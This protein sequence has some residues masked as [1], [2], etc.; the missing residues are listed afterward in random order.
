MKIRQLLNGAIVDGE[1]F[2]GMVPHP[3]LSGQVL[4]MWWNDLEGEWSIRAASLDDEVEPEEPPG[5]LAYY[6]YNLCV[7]LGLPV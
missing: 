6:K 3:V 1:T 7:A 5:E 4:C 2:V